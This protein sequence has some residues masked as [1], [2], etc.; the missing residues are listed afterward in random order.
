MLLVQVILLELLLWKHNEISSICRL[1]QMKE[2]NTIDQ[3]TF[4]NLHV[5]NA[6]PTNKCTKNELDFSVAADKDPETQTEEMRDH[7]NR[8]NSKD[9][10]L[11]QDSPSDFGKKD[12]TRD[13]NAAEV[14]SHNYEKR[15]HVK[16]KKSKHQNPELERK[17]KQESE[18]QID[19]LQNRE[20]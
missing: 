16:A 15:H 9:S 10:V 5:F 20:R 1:D 14:P 18:E 17:S 13:D 12:G 4:P 2:L 8:K 3:K 19:K 7:V 11:D 6:K